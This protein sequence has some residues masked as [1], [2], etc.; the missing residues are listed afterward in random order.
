[1]AIEKSKIAI[2]FIVAGI[3]MLLFGII[4]AIIGPTVMKNEVE[5]V[6]FTFDWEVCLFLYDNLYYREFILSKK[7]MHFCFKKHV[8]IF[9][10]I[11][12]KT[13]KNGTF[14]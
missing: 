13:F 2:G 7:I 11:F 10:Y 9:L 3:L 1:M 4:T 6:S 5:K 14:N 12:F 8:G